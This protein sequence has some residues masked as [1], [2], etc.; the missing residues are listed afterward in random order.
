MC[1]YP[2]IRLLTLS[3]RLNKVVV[4]KTFV[5]LSLLVLMETYNVFHKM[6]VFEFNDMVKFG[7]AFELSSLLP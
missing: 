7:Q 4:Y 3:E 2:K 5:F 6:I 1:L